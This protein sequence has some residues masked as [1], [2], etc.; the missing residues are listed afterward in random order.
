[1]TVIPKTQFDSDLF[2]VEAQ[3]AELWPRG[4]GLR[5]S[6]PLSCSSLSTATLFTLQ[7]NPIQIRF[8]LST[9]F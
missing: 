1:M 2:Y 7:A 6:G 4:S 5:L 9:P 8:A 3:T